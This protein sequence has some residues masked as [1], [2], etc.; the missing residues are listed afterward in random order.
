MGQQ[1]QVYIARAKK[2]VAI[3]YRED[4]KLSSPL[5]ITIPQTLIYM[6]SYNIY[7]YH[8]WSHLLVH[9]NTFKYRANLLLELIA[10]F[11]PW[12]Y[13]HN[14]SSKGST[15]LGSMLKFSR[16][17]EIKHCS[18]K[19]STCLIN[20]KSLDFFRSCRTIYILHVKP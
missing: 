9:N 14:I 2:K 17:P 8:I 3:L 6:L 11:L 20:G 4:P 16:Y 12:E 15:S 19:W 7:F 1:F 10:S 18:Y 5:I 13:I